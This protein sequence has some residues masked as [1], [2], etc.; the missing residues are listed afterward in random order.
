[1]SAIAFTMRFPNLSVLVS[2]QLFVLDKWKN[3]LFSPDMMYEQ[4]YPSRDND[5]SINLDKKNYF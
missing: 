5:Y 3:I 2:G 1:M 4:L